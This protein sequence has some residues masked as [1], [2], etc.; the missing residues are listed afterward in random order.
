METFGFAD[1]L[2]LETMIDDLRE[3]EDPAWNLRVDEMRAW[4]NGLFDGLT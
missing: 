1:V 3:W 4:A 2:S